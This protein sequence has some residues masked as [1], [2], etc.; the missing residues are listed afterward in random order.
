MH[1]DMER[2]REEY[3]GRYRDRRYQDK[4]RLISENQ[5]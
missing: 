4:H 2:S 1:I 3:R 5:R